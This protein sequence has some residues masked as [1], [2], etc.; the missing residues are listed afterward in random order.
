LL[1]E[2]ASQLPYRRGLATD[3]RF[4]ASLKTWPTLST[5]AK[6]VERTR[7]IDVDP[8]VVEI[9]DLI[10]EAYEESAIYGKVPVRKALAR[11][12]AEARNIVNAR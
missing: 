11:A 9:F 1:L 2:D 8:D 6:Y 3:P 5:Y 12:A 10:S 4:T 7:D